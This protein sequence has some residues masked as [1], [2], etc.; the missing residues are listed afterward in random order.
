MTRQ[1]FNERSGDPGNDNHARRTNKYLRQTARTALKVHAAG[2]RR[3]KHLAG[4]TREQ[5]TDIVL[6]VMQSMH[7]EEM[8]RQYAGH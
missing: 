5:Y 3:R 4:V 6:S 8:R 1:Y 7:E 2:R